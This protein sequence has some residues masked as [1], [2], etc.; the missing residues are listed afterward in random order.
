MQYKTEHKPNYWV[1]DRTRG[2]YSDRVR[3]FDVVA[4]SSP[5]AAWFFITS[6]WST[7]VPHNLDPWEYSFDAVTA[8]TWAGK[9]F[10][11]LKEKLGLYEDDVWECRIYMLPVMHVYEL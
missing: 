7:L 3:C 4:A 10:C 8:A 1:I 9:H 11:L 5:E 6:Y 2:T